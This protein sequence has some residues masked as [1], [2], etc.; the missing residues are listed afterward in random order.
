LRIIYPSGEEELFPLC[1][2]PL[3]NLTETKR[4]VE[5]GWIAYAEGPGNGQDITSFYASWVVPTDPVGTQS[6]PTNFFFTGLIPL[7]NS[8]IQPV[9]QW[10]RSEA[11]WSPTGWG[12]ASWYVIGSSNAVYSTLLDV[13]SGDTING[14]MEMSTEGTWYIGTS[15]QGSAPTYIMQS[16]LGVMELAC[17]TLEAYN[18][19]ACNDYPPDGSITFTDLRM[20]CAGQPCDP[21]LYVTVSKT[22]CNQAVQVSTSEV[23]ISW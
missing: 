2:P 9:L 21:T 11:G 22:D 13:K 16:G 1:D 6:D 10:G 5:D 12:I 4:W 14:T 7:G 17:V 15:V 3:H 19:I 20:N 8:I 18:V 23:T